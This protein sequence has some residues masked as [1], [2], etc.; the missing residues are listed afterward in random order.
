MCVLT[1]G[2]LNKLFNINC[3]IYLPKF[4][5]NKWT[6]SKFISKINFG[7]SFVDAWVTQVVLEY[8][9][10]RRVCICVFLHGRT[11]YAHKN[12]EIWWWRSPWL[13]GEEQWRWHLVSTC[14]L[15]L[16]VG[17][18]WVDPELTRMKPPRPLLEIPACPD[19][20]GT[21]LCLHVCLGRYLTGLSFHG[22]Q[23]LYLKLTCIFCLGW[24]LPRPRID[25]FSL[26]MERYKF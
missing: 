19:L 16:F 20:A 18:A 5:L 10:L 23:R 13:S 25:F 24:S 26:H 6:V 15:V 21:V 17:L 8:L 14:D 12:I 1:L 4:F 3:C 22:H 2:E 7:L 11:D 9:P